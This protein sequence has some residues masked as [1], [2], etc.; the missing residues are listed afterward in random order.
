MIEGSKLLEMYMDSPSAT[1]GLR[2]FSNRDYFQILQFA[3][4]KARILARS[5]ELENLTIG[6]GAI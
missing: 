2:Y 1:S 6:S 4:V 5:L 3:N